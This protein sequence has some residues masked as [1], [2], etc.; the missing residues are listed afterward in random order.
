V[1]SRAGKSLRPLAAGV[2]AAL[3]LLLLLATGSW[4][5][6]PRRIRSLRSFAPREL[7]VRRLGGSGAAFDRRYFSFL[8]N[9]RRRLP[10]ST[11]GVVIAN[12]P[13]TDPYVFL[14]AYALA[15]IPVSF[16]AAPPRRWVVA[17]YGSR[18]TP[19]ARVLAQLPEGFLTEPA[20]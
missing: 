2:S 17:I 1:T 11:P 16:A 7:A 10:R 19:G 9:A 14:A 20:P 15:P 12:A 8:E 4:R 18:P 5:E 13:D 6:L 3:L